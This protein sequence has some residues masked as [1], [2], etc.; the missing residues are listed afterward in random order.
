MHNNHTTLSQRQGEK[1]GGR[2]H[3]NEDCE[4][5][6]C[7]EVAKERKYESSYEE[8]WGIR[9]EEKGWMW[10]RGKEMSKE[11]TER[12]EGREII[13]KN[14]NDEEEAK[15]DDESWENERR[16][17]GN[18][19]KIDN[20]VG[21]KLKEWKRKKKERRRKKTKQEREYKKTK[22]KENMKKTKKKRNTRNAS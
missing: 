8:L 20:Y 1:E 19:I 9:R 11:M 2:T 13:R 22:N 10:I 3:N 16:G 14:G 5:A 6:T 21:R 12:E 15:M 7:E 4:I 18:G 17:E